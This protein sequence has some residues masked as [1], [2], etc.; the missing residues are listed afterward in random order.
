MKKI[1]WLLGV[2][3]FSIS[4]AVAQDP[5][6]V[7]ELG[8]QVEE[9]PPPPG[10]IQQAAFTEIRDERPRQAITQVAGEAPDAPPVT[11]I[12]L[13]D[14]RPP[15]V[16]AIPGEV[17][18]FAGAAPV[19]PNHR[20]ASP[21]ADPLGSFVDATTTNISSSTPLGSACATGANCDR[22]AGC[23]E[24]GTS[25]GCCSS[26]SS[27]QSLHTAE[28]L[29][30]SFGACRW[31]KLGAGLRTSYSAIEDGAPNNGA[32][33]GRSWGNDFR[34]DN[35]RIFVSGQAY[36]GI[37]FELNT[38]VNAAQGFEEFDYASG[39]GGFEQAG[40]MRILDGV[41][42]LQLTDE[43]N[44]WVGRHISPTDRTNLSSQFYLS[45]WSAP[46]AQ[47][48]YQN[49]FQGRDD[50]ATLWGE[51]MDGVFKWYFGLYEGRDG[52]AGPT[53]NSPPPSADKDDPYMVG[54]VAVHLLDSEPGYY[55]RGTYFGEKEIF[56]LG[57]G[58]SHQRNA[59]GSNALA[60][61]RDFFAW[62]FDALYETSLDSGS[63]VTVEAAYYDF[64]DND[65]QAID[66]A[67][68]FTPLGRQGESFTVQLSYLTAG[69]VNIGRWCGRLQP[70]LRYQDYNRDFVGA[71]PFAF[72]EGLDIGVHY[73]IDGHNAR[74]T[75]VWEQR[76]VNT[77]LGDGD[78]DIFRLGAQ[79]QF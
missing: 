23:D 45:A 32:G 60:D 4:R 14:L 66:P 39:F 72:D 47:F 15:Q 27:F 51:H 37:G 3:A 70:Y 79:L 10:A 7:F 78:I 54:R 67:G 55:N 18:N 22:T 73:V 50:G 34:M 77:A 16:P 36:E 48:G 38:G 57:W 20:I 71:G 30:Y 62:S 52:L 40:G 65:A 33:T 64:D 26:C 43:L 68:R 56:T 24:C 31:I 8:R 75:A 61:A 19:L 44:L 53:L 35:M 9:L 63:V 11:L 28:G 76:E 13:P 25:G 21:N 69:S 46:Y 5:L 29:F 58:F 2:F 1:P 12:D 42:K 17:N 41:V 74:L 59:T 49:I 6:A